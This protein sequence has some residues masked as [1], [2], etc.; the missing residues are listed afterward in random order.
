MI[1]ER[2]YKENKKMYY[3]NPEFYLSYRQYSNLLIIGKVDS[4][5]IIRDLTGADD[6]NHLCLQSPFEIRDRK[7]NII[8]KINSFQTLGIPK[9][10]NISI[11]R[12][13]N[14]TG[15]EFS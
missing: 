2:E 8:N 3:L 14:Y 6:E 13:K 10:R 1:K 4:L 11:S 7:A 9:I 5:L 15:H 12:K